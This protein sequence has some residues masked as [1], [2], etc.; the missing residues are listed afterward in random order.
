V[1]SLQTFTPTRCQLK[2]DPDEFELQRSPALAAGLL[3][4]G[5]QLAPVRKPSCAKARVRPVPVTWPRF[6]VP[7]RSGHRARNPRQVGHVRRGF[8]STLAAASQ[9]RL[10][11]TAPTSFPCSLTEFVALP[12]KMVAGAFSRSDSPRRVRSGTVKPALHSG[13]ERRRLGFSCLDCVGY[14]QT[15][16][17]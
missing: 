10:R 13:R 4:L 17:N 6:R 5:Q 2:F 15:P 3:L 16:V 12:L 14:N 1:P 9:F 11:F 7:V 8:R